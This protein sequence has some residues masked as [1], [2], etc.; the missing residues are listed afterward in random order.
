MEGICVLWAQ[1]THLCLGYLG[2]CLSSQGI[3]IEMFKT[4][5]NNRCHT[6]QKFPM[7]QQS[8]YIYV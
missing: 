5:S 4:I 3:K 7:G 1:M 2:I 6:S 8:I